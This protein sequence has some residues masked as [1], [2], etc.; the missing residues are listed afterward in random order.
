MAL[1]KQGLSVVLL[2]V[3]AVCLGTVWNALL[4]AVVAWAI[5]FQYNLGWGFASMIVLATLGGIIK[6]GKQA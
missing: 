2:F 3:A 6:R 4:I 5:G 1:D